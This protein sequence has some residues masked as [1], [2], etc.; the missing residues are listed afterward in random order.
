[1]KSVLEKVQSVPGVRVAVPVIEAVVDSG[2]P[3][4]GNLLILGVDM[5]GDRSLRDYDLENGDE[6]VMEDPLVF[7]A[8][9]DSLIVTR[10][11]AQATGLHINSKLKMRTMDGEKQFTVRG[12]MKAGGLSSAFG[13]NLAVMDVYSAQKVFGRGLRFDHIDLAVNEGVSV[14][15]VKSRIQALLGSGYEVE[16]PSARG[17]HFEEMARNFSISI[18]FSS[19]FAL[20]IGMFIIYNSFAIAVTQRRSEIGIVRALGATQTQIRS[21]FL[22]EGAIAGVFGS[23]VG[24]SLASCS[25]AESRRTSADCSDKFTESRRR[26]K[27]FRHS[28]NCWLAR[29]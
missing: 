17:Q 16:P 18:N 4:Q 25:R 27:S 6:E 23:I 26:R 15:D 24:C 19:I 28:R 20:L 21:L 2:I 14:D 9:P 5:L 10:P 22:A 13:G 3:G 1:M 7:L 29:C 8:Q 12:I 11:F